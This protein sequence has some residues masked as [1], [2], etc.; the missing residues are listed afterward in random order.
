LGLYPPLLQALPSLNSE[1][2]TAFLVCG[3][4]FHFCTLFQETRRFGWHHFAAS[5]YLAY[6]ALTKIFF[7][8]V[9]ATILVFLFASLLWKRT[10]PVRKALAVFLLAM[11]WCVPYLCYMYSVTGKVFYWGT[12]GGM[13]LYWISSPYTGEYGS[14]YSSNQVQERPELAPHL[15]FFASLERLTDVE[16]DTAYRKQAI[17]NITSHPKEYVRNWAANVGRL[18]FSYPF[19]FG[20]QSLTTY[21]YLAPNMFVVVLFL[22]SLIPAALRPRAVPLELWFLLAFALVAFGGSTLVSGYERQ[23]RPLVPILF[24]WVAFVCVRL[25]RIELRPGPLRREATD[26]RIS[27]R[28]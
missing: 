11:L 10:Q 27:I 9:I 22:V 18:L 23:F 16:R 26:S 24:V 8:Y 2:V 15:Q 19:S 21:F 25:L 1:A 12:S 7:G 20:P 28:G 5:L 17:R 4:M 14:W 6:L 13:S 3:F